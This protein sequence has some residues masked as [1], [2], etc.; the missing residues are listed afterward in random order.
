MSSRPH[1]SA[2]LFPGGSS[3]KLWPR[4]QVM[5]KFSCI[6][7]QQQQNHILSVLLTAMRIR[8]TFWIYIRAVNLPDSPV[9]Q[10]WCSETVA[11]WHKLHNRYSWLQTKYQS[12][13]WVG[14]RKDFCFIPFRSVCQTEAFATYRLP[15]QLSAF[16][17]SMWLGW[18]YSVRVLVRRILAL[19]TY[20]TMSIYFVVMRPAMLSLLMWW[21]WRIGFRGMD[22]TLT[23]WN[24]VSHCHRSCNKIFFTARGVCPTLISKLEKHT[25]SAVFILYSV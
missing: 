4:N 16:S 22:W 13:Y 23:L 25:A 12:F 1:T 3:V 18:L 11:Y 15:P 7:Y 10:I 17:C 21:I 5:R 19:I 8:R 20:R 14:E 6:T 9:W 2:A 24:A